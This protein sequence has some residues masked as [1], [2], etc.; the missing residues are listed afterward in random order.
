MKLSNLSKEPQ[1]V[2]ILVDDKEIVEE[3][4][5]ALSFHTWDRQPMHI[6]VQLANLSQ[7]T[8]S[9]NPNI[10]KMLELVKALI[11]DE[12]GKEIITDSA[13]LPTNVL[14]KVIGKVTETLGK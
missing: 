7:E 10:G 5:E 12:K 2:E 13:S 6:F 1:L 9:K 4:G 11:L 3:Y 8:E 14:I